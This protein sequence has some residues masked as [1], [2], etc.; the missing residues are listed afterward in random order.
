MD[1]KFENS[2]FSFPKEDFY[3]SDAETSS[4]ENHENNEDKNKLSK[5][6]TKSYKKLDMK[7]LVGIAMFA[8]LAYGVTFVFRLPVSFLTFDA[9]DA[10]LT[11]AA[12]IYG[13]I[14]A[15]IMSCIAALIEFITIS[16]TGVY[17]L[18]MNFSSSAVFSGTAALVYKYRR[19]F[20]GAIISIYSASIVTVAFM[21]CLNLLVT[22]YYMGVD[23]DTVKRLIPGLLLPFN[24]AKVLMNSALAMLLYKPVSQAMRRAG[25]IKGRVDMSFNR[26]SIVLL[27]IITLTLAASIT[28]FIVTRAMN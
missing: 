5:N 9:K 28:L 1:N 2:E 15:V 11:V 23:I 6:S 14:A 8:S 19:S 10:V 18:I 3:I 26:R 17:G 27:V 7:R 4:N 16:G 25:L 12:F 22:P 13:P 21:M 24:T 20:S